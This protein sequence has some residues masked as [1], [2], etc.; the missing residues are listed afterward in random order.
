[1]IEPEKQKENDGILEPEEIKA[2]VSLSVD[3]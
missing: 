1:M 3:I 2:N